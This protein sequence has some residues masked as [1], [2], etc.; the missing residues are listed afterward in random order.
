MLSRILSCAVQGIDAYSVSVE[1]DIAAGLPTF[2]TVGLPDAAV[3]ESKDRVVAAVRN[4]GFDFPVRK[5]TVN[6][7]PADIK[8]EGAAFDLP[9]AAGILAALG[10]LN[11]DH[12][13]GTA[14]VGE[15]A[16]DGTLRPVRGVLPIALHL[17]QAG[18]GRLVLPDSNAREAAVIE[19]LQVFPATCLRQVV[20][21]LNGEEEIAPHPTVAYRSDEA[22]G[23]E[24]DF[25]DV[26]GQ[27]FAKRALEI[28]AAGGHN[29]IMIGPPGSGKTMLARRLPGIL[30]PMTL[31]EAIET[32][33]VHSVA[34]MLTP[35]SGLMRARPF[36]APHH[37]VS[38]IALI[39]GGTT[40][41]PGEVS[42]A[43]NGILFLDELTELHRDV[44]EVLRQPLEDR[45]VT[46]SRAKSSLSFPASFMLVGAMNPC[47]CGNFGHSEK[48]CLCTPYKI[49]KY[50]TKISGPLLDRID[51]HLEIPALKVA[52][53]TDD[54]SRAEPS[55]AIRER[56]VAARA[57]QRERFAGA[58]VHSNAQMHS[59]FVRK[60]CTLDEGGKKL[61]RSA[62][63]R[64]GLSGRAYDRTLKV[65]RT[66]A[67]MDGKPTIE[68]THIAEAIQYRNL[69][70]YL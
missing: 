1:V 58:K 60:F 68:E 16:L 37:T 57:V 38:D 39:G 40:P 21:F 22:E 52:E 56:V 8:K 65:S 26:K 32:T 35:G 25:S 63:E 46:I 49:Q 59:R 27:Q 44:L 11:P 67:D 33:K 62:I 7:A 66:I 24:L 30:P 15:L 13:A 41:R 20:R 31:Q 42:L 12:L 48:E 4:S 47:P 10:T 2:S 29:V 6:L 43:H 18:I 64:L 36:R 5:I 69:D 54:I 55:A 23:F 61:L 28:A 70:R 9:I 51:I 17:R 45:V 14:L 34:G 50:R 19:G 3:K 53:L